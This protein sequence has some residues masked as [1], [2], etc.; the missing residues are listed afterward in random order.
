MRRVVALLA[1]VVL[2][3]SF[4]GSSAA[5]TPTPRVNSFV[6]SFSLAEEGTWHSWGLVVASLAMPT[7]QRLV[8]GTFV[9]Y[10]SPDNSIRRSEALIGNAHFWYD[11]NNS[12]GG[13]PGANVAF[14]EGVNCI[15][16]GPNNTT[17]QPF[18][19]M[20]IDNIDPTVPN[21]VAFANHKDDSDN[22]VFE[23]WYW[24]GPGLFKLTY[25]VDS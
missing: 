10:G 3:A 13:K 24:V 12:N 22:W 23:Y 14:G 1:A 2:T 9:Q 6:G 18:A 5:A 8:P 7:D 15:Y 16:W 17:C 25:V 20:Y 21:Q 19:V 4:A 11:P